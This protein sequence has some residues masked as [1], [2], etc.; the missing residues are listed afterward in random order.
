MTPEQRHANMAA[1]HSKDTKPELVVRRYLWRHGFRYRLN[2][3]RLPGKPDIVLRKYK[4][5]IF[6]NGCFWHGHHIRFDG[7][8]PAMPVA[9]SACCRIPRTNTAFWVRKIRRNQSRDQRV[10][11]EL[12]TMG[13]N[14][15]TIW[16]CQLKPKEREKTLESLAY[17][18]VRSFLDGHRVK[19]YDLDEETPRIA[20]EEEGE[21]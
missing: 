20:A 4:T 10:E 19:E 5:C 11:D 6:V 1:I 3:P 8:D 13:W 12:A 7:D 21:F 18:L 17:T 9:D 2:H 16:E 15:I 14:S